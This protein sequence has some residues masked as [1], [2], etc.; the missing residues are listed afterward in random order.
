M[1]KS[2]SKHMAK[3]RTDARPR[4]C[5][6][7]TC[8]SK[9]KTTMAMRKTC[10]TV[11]CSHATFQSSLPRAAPDFRSQE[12]GSVCGLRHPPL[13]PS[14]SVAFH[15][16]LWGC[17][18]RGAFSS[19]VSFL[20]GSATAA[21]EA[22]PYLPHDKAAAWKTFRLELPG[23]HS[24]RAPLRAAAHQGKQAK[25]RA[26]RKTKRPKR[27]TAGRVRCKDAPPKLGQTWQAWWQRRVCTGGATRG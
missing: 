2:A 25:R 6:R 20:G 19:S 26:A 7:P 22:A 27:L 14:H 5:K 13:R 3:P 17:A 12:P 1:H 24:H 4:P 8:A 18:Q 15:T 16:S 21:V 23:N 10:P 9:T 11:D